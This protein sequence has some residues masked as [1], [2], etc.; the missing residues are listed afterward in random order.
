MDNLPSLQFGTSALY[1]Y[2]ASLVDSLGE[3]AASL[4]AGLSMSC[5]LKTGYAGDSIDHDI[6]GVS[7]VRGASCLRKL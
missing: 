5:V 4:L 6:F 2:G 7:I 3:S 1:G